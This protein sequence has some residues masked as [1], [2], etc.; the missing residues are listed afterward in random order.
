MNE[1][2]LKAQ[3]EEAKTLEL[4]TSTFDVRSFPLQ[5]RSGGGRNATTYKF[6]LGSNIT[7]KTYFDFTHTLFEVVQAS[8]TLQHNKHHFLRLYRPP[9]NRRKNLTDYVY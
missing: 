6:I 3:G 1:A 7:I 8:I 2:W 4:A 9:P 5:S